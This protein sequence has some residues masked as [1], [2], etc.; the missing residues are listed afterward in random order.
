MRCELLSSIPVHNVIDINKQAAQIPLQR[1][2]QTPNT[3]PLTRSA[4]S[5]LAARTLRISLCIKG[6]HSTFSHHIRHIRSSDVPLRRCGQQ[7]PSRAVLPP[8]GDYVPNFGQDILTVYG[9]HKFYK[10]LLRRMSSPITQCAN[11]KHKAGGAAFRLSC[12]ACFE[13]AA[14]VFADPD[15]LRE[16]VSGTK[17][18]KSFTFDP[19][20]LILGTKNPK[21]F[22]F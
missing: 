19:K 13:G 16:L 8:G 12:A 17:I 22:P 18:Y 15:A 11:A 10:S 20:S 6:L 2:I 14:G 1:K 9:Q 3:Q 4:C 5:P 7:H 21:S